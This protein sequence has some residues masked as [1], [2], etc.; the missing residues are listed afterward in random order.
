MNEHRGLKDVM[1][2]DA[3]VIVPVV[4]RH[5]GDAAFYWSQLD[6]AAR[7]PLL[8]LQGLLHFEKLL[9]AH[10]EGIEEAADTGWD[11]ALRALRRWRSAGEVFVCAWLV[12][13]LG[14]DRAQSRWGEVEQV[15]ATD[16]R[17]MLRGVVAALLRMPPDI[18]ND[19]ASRFLQTGQPV[20]LQVA[21]WRA[22]AR[23]PGLAGGLKQKRIAERWQGAAHGS[24]AYLRAAAC[25]AAAGHAQAVAHL[26]SDTNQT[27]C[28][29]AGIAT[30]QAGGAPG[31]RALWLALWG[32]AGELPRL[33]GA[34]RAQAEHRLARWTGYLGT[35]VPHGHG[36][37][38]ELL[39]LL[40]ARMALALVLQHGDDRHLP[41][42]QG[43]LANPECARMAGWV[44]AS[45]LG[46]DLERLGLA[47]PPSRS[48][49]QTHQP[50]DDV[51]PGLPL[52]NVK[53]IEDFDVAGVDPAHRLA[54]RLKTI[55]G[56]M[57]LLEHGP[58][59]LRAIAAR[60]LARLDVS[61]SG[62]PAFFDIKA[63]ARLQ[64]QWL[65]AARA[66]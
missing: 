52:P 36:A 66:H 26:L 2:S 3:R 24:D 60:H 65:N 51:D 42:V 35:L 13:R 22:M 37:V 49:E 31:L 21:A 58:Q 32:L 43:H 54:N 6:R 33:S 40:P 19:W 16:P 44:W 63:D 62:R 39:K 17:R 55:Q 64:R 4:E 8:G 53:A 27:V 11:L 15:L 5:V 12:F 50:T 18:A 34:Y 48:E 41:W 56:C 9:T 10:L 28:A 20:M 45:L 1:E 47:H 57:D 59:A 46:V 29:E 61:P 23:Q 38:V 25:R 30:A 14:P 7:S